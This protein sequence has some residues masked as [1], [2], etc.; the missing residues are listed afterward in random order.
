MRTIFV[1]RKIVGASTKASASSAIISKSPAL[2]SGVARVPSRFRRA[3]A[4]IVSEQQCDV[5]MQ[6]DR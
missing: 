3:N 5:H 2:A 6:L 1:A 4:G